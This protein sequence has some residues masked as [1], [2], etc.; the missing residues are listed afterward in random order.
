[1]KGTDIDSHR[2]AKGDPVQPGP[3]GRLRSWPVTAFLVTIPLIIGIALALATAGYAADTKMPTPSDARTAFERALMK[4]LAEVPSNRVLKRAHPRSDFDRAL[5][6]AV[7]G[8]RWNGGYLGVHTQN[9]DEA[10]AAGL[11]VGQPG[12]ALIT[13]VYEDSAASRAGLKAGDVVVRFGDKK[14]LC[15][16]CLS[17]AV[18][19]SDPGST[20]SLVVVRDGRTMPVTVVLGSRK[21]VQNNWLGIEAYL[22]TEDYARSLDLKDAV[23]TVVSAVRLNSPAERAGLR[24]GDVIVGFDGQ[25]VRWVLDLDDL[26]HKTPVGKRVEATVIRGG[27]TMKL[28]IVLVAGKPPRTAFDF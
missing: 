1:M 11:K 22:L 27:K 8:L 13:Q 12:G 24:P 6:R 3:A 28:A 26:V 4:Y 5:A 15:N 25:P 23:G 14:I 2:I 16:V 9:I 18:Y 7:A 19:Y 17:D 20:A 21:P 10:Q